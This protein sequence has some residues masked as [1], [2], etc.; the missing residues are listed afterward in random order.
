MLKQ[1]YWYCVIGPAN[2]DEYKGNGAD[3]PLR[4]A[5]RE[6]FDKHFG[7][8]PRCSSGWGITE[9]K[10]RQISFATCN[11]DLKRSIIRSYHNENKPLPRHMRAWELLFQEESK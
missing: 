8:S 5:V 9:E 11:D 6:A 7:G 10:T 3:W 4:H 1:E 2:P